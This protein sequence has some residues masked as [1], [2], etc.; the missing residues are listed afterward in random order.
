MSRSVLLLLIVFNSVVALA[1]GPV[2]RLSQYAHASWRLQDGVFNGV[3]TA[4]VQTADGYLWIGT[5]S[6]LMRFDGV[7]LVTWTPPP[8][9]SALT[10][11]VYSLGASRDGSL[12]IG[13]SV[14]MRWKDGKLSGYPNLDARINAIL[15]D[16]AGGVWVTRSRIRD[17]QGPLCHIVDDQVKCFGNRDGI[18]IPY[19]GPLFR[20]MSGTLWLGGSGGL[21]RGTPGSFVTFVPPALKPLDQLSGVT[22]LANGPNGSMLVGMAQSGR[23]L[24]LQEF[25]ADHWNPFAGDGFDGSTLQINNLLLDRSGSLWIGTVSQGLGVVRDRRIDYFRSSD[26]LSSNVINAI[27]EDR[28]NNIWVVTSAGLDRFRVPKVLTFSSRE[29]LS[30]DYAGSVVAASDGTV[31]VGN[32][33]ALDEVH[34]GVV[35]SIRANQGLPGRRVTVLLEDHSG[36][37]WVGVDNTLSVREGGRFHAL[38]R[39]D[40]SPVG[41]LQ[42]LIED[43]NGDL[44]GRPVPSS[45]RLIHIHGFT[46]QEESIGPEPSYITSIA[47]DPSGGIRV[48]F[49]NGDI[50]LYANGTMSGVMTG[51]KRPVFDLHPTSDGHVLNLASGELISWQN[52]KPQS[53]GLQNGLPCNNSYTF[54]LDR[55]GTLWLYSSC[56]LIEISNKELQRWWSDPKAK[57]QYSLFDIFDGAQGG[58]TS[59]TP[60]ASEAPDGKLWFVNGITAQMIDP[61][62]LSTNG[63]APPVHIESLIADRKSYP[64]QQ[65][66]RL[67]PLTHDLE[68]DYT[69]LSFVVPQKVQF[70][71]RLEGS[72]KDWQDPGTRRQVFYT[73]L[74]PGRYRFHV[75]ASNNDGVWNSSE[76]SFEFTIEPALYQTWWLKTASVLVALALIAWVIR[77]RMQIVA[78]NIHARLAE[79]L[80]ERERIARE[81]HDTLLQG[82]MSASIQLD[83]AEDQLAEDSPVKGLLQNALATLRQVI[84][85]GRTAL[86]GLRFQ[87]VENNDLAKAFQRIKQEFPHKATIMFG[88]LAQG[89]PRVVRTEIGDEIYRIGREAILNAYVHSEA[90][91]IEVEIQYASTHL[92]LLVRDDGRGIDSSILEGGR[93]GHWGLV[94]MRERSQRIGGTLKL[95][96]RAGAG[97]EIELMVP[98]D[99]AFEGES[100]N[101]TPRWL[102]WLGREGFDTIGRKARDKRDERGE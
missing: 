55:Q 102:R 59:F 70:R 42:G 64:L 51:G 79:R 5:T 90:A 78:R 56:G 13:S 68:I 1:Q 9:A 43:Q 23:D 52:G 65:A 35:S 60:K 82:A 33:D 95:R 61:K 46:V 74:D 99:I 8:E 93:D 86:R 39:S 44:W 26:G 12:W 88:V 101:S 54:I 36:R 81:M 7:R 89:A 25:Q 71:Y 96:S 48:G 16:P 57:L 67:P 87:D 75:I 4:I 30:S 22:A 41:T 97:T 49:R 85:E 19:A 69:G 15:E 66:L 6:G 37:L 98:G 76:A 63:L 18:S 53:L 50:A 31:W 21:A 100:G 20:D 58:D 62:N 34:E 14:L 92:G 80:D 32:H 28:E 94:G 3:P 84:E 2:L 72:D 10:H 27:Y 40:G 24:G 73:N 77:R 91:T 11:G 83:L 17:G 29:G 45:S 38:S 47:A